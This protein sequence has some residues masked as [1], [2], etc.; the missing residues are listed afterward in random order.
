MVLELGARQRGRAES[1][2]WFYLRS[3]PDGEVVPPSAIVKI[4][5]SRSEPLQIDHNGMFPAVSLSL[6]LAAR[7]PP[8]EAV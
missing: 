6:N 1:L 7:V 5:A 4:M 8:G 3:P 2:D